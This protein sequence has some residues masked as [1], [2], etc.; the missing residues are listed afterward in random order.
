M[1]NYKSDIYRESKVEVVFTIK[2]SET[3]VHCQKN[4]LK[5]EEIAKWG[6]ILQRF[7][8][9]ISSQSTYNKKLIMNISDFKVFLIN[10]KL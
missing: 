10:D 2:Y 6:G 9:S 1:G 3:H 8:L 5:I 4:N 7:H